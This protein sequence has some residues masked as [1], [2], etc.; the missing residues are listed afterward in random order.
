VRLSGKNFQPWADF[1]LE[2]GG[3]TVLTG[4]SNKGKSSLS[5]ALRGILRNELDAA[6]IRDPKKEPLE[7]T[8][9][10]NGTTIKATRNKAGKV[11]YVLNG[12]EKNAYTSLD[13]HIPPPVKD[14]L[15]GEI[16]IGDFD[17]DPIFAV[18][19]DPQFL[20]D[21]RAYKP[22]DLNAILGAFG[23]TEKLEAG[24]KEA[25]SRVSDKNGEAK[26]LA[27]E[28]REA[29]ERKDKLMVLSANGDCLQST[30]H[31]LE[32]RIRL[33]DAK[34]VWVGEA[35][36]R[37]ARL[38]PLERLQNALAVPNTVTAEQLAQQ[39]AYLTQASESRILSKWLGK[40]TTVI[41]GTSE[42]WAALLAV[43]RKLVAVET[44]RDLIVSRREFPNIEDTGAQ[45]SALVG[46]YSSI[47]TI[48]QVIELRRSLKA[49]TAELTQI[50][51][52]L[53][54]AQEDLKKGL[55]PKC[56][57]DGM[58]PNCGKRLAIPQ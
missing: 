16:T 51:S 29:E 57:F 34:A 23:G 20:L 46:L 14:L 15:C 7:L 26:T 12:D 5:R 54:Q 38:K 41:D 30:L 2:I 32:L 56:G 13:G 24:K 53:T 22:A 52:E 8:L 43:W 10:I 42:P 36:S 6:Y 35:T 18:Q 27:A 37:L 49:K 44:L 19:N 40:V 50:D 33:L 39:I 25:G 48:G 21:K 9:E 47:R 45:Y 11:K 3:L 17:F 58:C 28:I 55:C 31:E 1:E 4:P